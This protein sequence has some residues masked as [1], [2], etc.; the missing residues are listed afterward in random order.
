[1]HRGQKKGHDRYYTM[2]TWIEEIVNEKKELLAKMEDGYFDCVTAAGEVMIKSLAEGHKIMTAGNGGSCADAQHFT[3]EIVG[4][5]LMEREAMAAVTLGVDPSVTTS[6]GNDFGYDQV[7]ARQVVGVGQKGDVL[8]LISTS[9]N[10]SNL[11]EAI[12][13]A[14]AKGITT[15]GLLGKNGGA[16]KDL[17]DHVMIVPSNSTPRI[18]E[19]HTFTVHLLCQ[20][21]EREL[22]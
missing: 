1:M 12:K 11:I 19:M 5:F 7:I 17:C 18:Q 16:M 4:R 3:G 22:N 6:L 9:G 13:S 20:M 8:L 21:L 15:I 2:T 10:S 14:K